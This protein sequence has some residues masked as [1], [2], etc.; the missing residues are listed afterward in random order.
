MSSHDQEPMLPKTGSH[1]HHT[2]HEFPHPAAAQAA[3]KKKKVRKRAPWRIH[4]GEILELH[5]VEF[6][7]VGLIVLDVICVLF[8]ILEHVGWTKEEHS[9][10]TFISVL[11]WTSRTILLIFAIEICLKIAAFGRKFLRSFWHVFDFF[12]VFVCVIVE[13]A[14][15]ILTSGHHVNEADDHGHDIATGLLALYVIVV[16]FRFL[17]IIHVFRDLYE[18][19]KKFE[20][21]RFHEKL[22][23]KDLEIQEL[24]T[25]LHKVEAEL[26]E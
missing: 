16:I 22:H 3:E 7:I 8:E 1:T 26:V 18:I 11:A 12:V 25:K 4:L 24:K 23:I 20:E 9:V 21:E 19:N 14:E 2:E 6:A 17:R 13:T 15:A 5:A 10:E